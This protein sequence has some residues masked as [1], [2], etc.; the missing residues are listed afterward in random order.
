M[1]QGSVLVDQVDKDGVLTEGYDESLSPNELY[2]IIKDSF[3]NVKKCPDDTKVIV[4]EYNGNRFTI[5]CKNITYLGN[6]HPHYKKRIQ[7]ATELVEFYEFSMSIKAR[8]ILLG[9]YS[10]SGNTIF[11]E[12][13]IDT[14]VKKKAHN[15]SAHIYVGDLAI[16]TEE[17]FFQKTDY[18]GNELTAFRPD[19]VDVFMEDFFSSREMKFEEKEGSADTDTGL[20]QSIPTDDMVEVEDEARNVSVIIDREN[21]SKNSA[22][23]F[24]AYVERFKQT[25]VPKVADFFKKEDKTW[26]GITC[27]EEMIQANY[28]NK[29]QPEWAGFYLEF[30][31]EKYISEESISDLV[32][33][34]QDK[35]TGG[36]DLDLYFPTIESYGDLK[37]HNEESSGVPGNDW[38]TVMKILGGQDEKSHIYYIICEHSTEKDSAHDNE[39]TLFWN[40][41]QNKS[42]PMSYA[43][44]M[45]H[46]VQL[47]RV[48]IL[49][50][51]YR[52]M[53]YLTKFKQGINSN[54]KPRK[55]KIMIDDINM[56][57]FILA[58]IDL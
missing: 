24:Y 38:N 10:F 27:Y 15:S 37:A 54:G 57:H 18:F 26:N 4:G 2:D 28:K 35:K 40:K 22:D 6:P 53:E 25:I 21:K 19:T 36:I 8:P 42:N 30:E 49:D 47:K 33:Y 58:Q 32:R 55:P 9:V 1:R 56:E 44:K 34:A 46:S 5:R 23:R 12:F 45:K 50:I 7:I 43:K 20:G 11:V 13:G 48:Y 29:F 52:N 51:N 39:V 3:P 16:A 31:F 14:Y 41:A 17:G